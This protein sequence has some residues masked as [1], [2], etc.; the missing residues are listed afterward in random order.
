MKIGIVDTG[1][2]TNL[3]C[4][5]KEDRFDVSSLF[6]HKRSSFSEVE[7]FHGHGTA[8]ASFLAALCPEATLAPVRIAQ[9]HGDRCTP[10]VPEKDIALGIN[11][12]IDNR[13]R[14][15][16]ISYSIEEVLDN[17]PLIATC[18]K[19]ADNNVILVASFRNGSKKPVYPAAF[20]TVIGVTVRRDLDHAQIAIVSEK[21]HNVAAFGGPYQI[22]SP[23]SEP[24]IVSGTSFATA[25]VTAMIARMLTIRAALTLKQ[26][27]RYL[28]KYATR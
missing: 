2:M 11:W 14:L 18:R 7:D 27:F 8:V 9:V 17:G 16:N 26:A 5:D 10:F 25:Q 4:E 6:D 19:A 22:I 13:I 12:C 3:I 21:N 24:K 15:I 1:I 23:G 20:P 28:T